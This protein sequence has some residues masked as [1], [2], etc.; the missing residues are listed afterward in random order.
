MCETAEHRGRGTTVPT[1][2]HVCPPT[3]G[4]TSCVTLAKLLSLPVPQLSHLENGNIR[5][6][7][8]SV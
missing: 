2:A 7:T 8:G 6:P 3:P 1:T 5:E 4:R